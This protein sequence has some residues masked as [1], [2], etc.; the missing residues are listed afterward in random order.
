MGNIRPTF[1]KLRAIILCEEHGERSQM[2]LTQQEDGRATNRCESKS[3][4][5]GL[6]VM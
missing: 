3:C 1:I 2:I 4:E 6:L 5:I